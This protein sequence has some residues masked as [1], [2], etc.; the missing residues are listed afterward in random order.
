MNNETSQ[1]VDELARAIF[2]VLDRND[3]LKQASPIAV[4][5]GLSGG[6]RRV[7]RRTQTLW[8]DYRREARA[9]LQRSRG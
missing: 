4:A 5:Q 6:P 3:R 2:D 8:Q 1:L 7:A 9:I